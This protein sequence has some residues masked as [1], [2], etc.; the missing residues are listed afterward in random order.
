MDKVRVLKHHAFQE[1][2]AELLNS[3]ATTLFGMSDGIAQAFIAG[4]QNTDHLIF[5]DLDVTPD[6]SNLAVSC[7]L[8]GVFLYRTDAEN[9]IWGVYKGTRPDKNT[10]YSEE[11]LPLAAADPT[12][13]RI[14]ILEAEIV[15]EDDVDYFQT[16]QLFNPGT[17][18]SFAQDQYIKRV[19]NVKLYVKT[20]V[21]APSPVAPFATAGRMAVKEIHVA[22]NAT[23][24]VIGDI[25]S[26]PLD[27]LTSEWT[28]A[29]PTKKFP[30]IYEVIG[31]VNYELSLARRQIF[32]GAGVYLYQ[33]PR[34]RT[35][36]YLRVASGGG[37][38]ESAAVLSVDR[39]AG[40]DGEN[41]SI[42]GLDGGVLTV[43]GG[44]AGSQGTPGRAN[45]IY[46]N[47]AN[48]SLLVSNS[49]GG[50]PDDEKGGY[51]AGINGTQAIGRN[52]FR[53]GGVVKV[54]GQ[55]NGLVYFA[56]NLGV[57]LVVATID[58][59]K[60]TN[61]LLH[62]GITEP[63]PLSYD[64]LYASPDGEF[65]IIRGYTSYWKLDRSGNITHY[66][67][68][69]DNIAYGNTDGAAGVN[70]VQTT[71]STSFLA[72]DDQNVGGVILSERDIFTLSPNGVSRIRRV[73]ANGDIVTEVVLPVNNFLYEFM[74]D[75]TTPNSVVGH[76]SAGSTASIAKIDRATGT[77]THVTG[78]NAE[79][80]LDGALGTAKVRLVQAV[81]YVQSQD[82]LIFIDTDISNVARLR[83]ISNY[84]TLV[85]SVVGTL[86]A[87][88]AM[89]NWVGQGGYFHEASNTFFM[90][91][92]EYPAPVYTDVVAY[93]FNTNTLSIV[94]K[95]DRSETVLQIDQDGSG[96][97]GGGGAGGNA[98]LG[99]EFGGAG[100]GALMIEGQFDVS[101]GALLTITVGAG[102]LGGVSPDGPLYNGHAGG[103]G[104]VEVSW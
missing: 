17:E 5:Q 75:P 65:V 78:L 82:R 23:S 33:V 73:S 60:R 95:S 37:G 61:V 85:G 47:K 89:E 8:K 56:T 3:I 63:F 34:Y 62:A 51:G 32:S 1:V 83:Y 35:K 86:Y 66:I 38:G 49:S 41:T 30:S 50:Y 72:T 39:E 104:F 36:V 44:K 101:P 103:D 97:N 67:G 11:V 99:A 80:F 10:P 16:V 27:Y 71:N 98:L 18:T 48:P 28:T 24:I 43:F 69:P 87:T 21:A 15:E 4:F 94:K 7:G 81:A 53:V 13:P 45:G 46:G 84:S 29:N 58:L 76:Y 31:Y 74:A 100:G 52:K 55:D 9:S 79:G 54:S 19:R 25:K 14:D 2:T 40:E 42:S 22:Q 92:S 96:V 90:F 6:G 12:N 88:D 102:G 26:Q 20:G 77:V 68:D 57:G 93:N 70:R 64:S 91:L 59:Q